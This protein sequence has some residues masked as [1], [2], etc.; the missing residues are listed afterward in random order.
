MSSKIS[1][2]QVNILFAIIFVVVSVS[3]LL[4]LIIAL[5]IFGAAI[6][7]LM[8]TVYPIYASL[9]AIETVNKEYTGKWLTHWIAF[10][11]F[12][13]LESLALSSS[14]PFYYLTKMMIFV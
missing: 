4:V 8:G 14:I 1:D 6:S 11:T 12:S 10:A 5:E 2:A 13:V 3:V 9:E 7:T